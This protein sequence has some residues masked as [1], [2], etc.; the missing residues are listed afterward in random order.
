VASGQRDGQAIAQVELN[1]YARQGHASDVTDT[2]DRITGR[3]TQP[4]GAVGTRLTPRRFGPDT[5]ILKGV[6]A[7]V[8]CS[9]AQVVRTTL[10]T[11]R[12]ASM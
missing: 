1:T 4:D 8:V 5:D 6:L 9:F 7:A 3:H 10:P 12:R 11:F 2:V